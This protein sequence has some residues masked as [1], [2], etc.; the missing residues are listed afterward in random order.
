MLLSKD[1][2]FRAILNE[3]DERGIYVFWI[4]QRLRVSICPIVLGDTKNCIHSESVS[5]SVSLSLSLMHIKY[6]K[7]INLHIT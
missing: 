5:V 4:D 7:W 3:N 1:W 6:R 2:M